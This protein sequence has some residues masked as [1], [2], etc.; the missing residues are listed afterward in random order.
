MNGKY[1]KMAFDFESKDG[2]QNGKKTIEYHDPMLGIQ[3]CNKIY[4]D[5]QEL[6]KTEFGEEARS[7]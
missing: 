7:I 4:R 6:K 3:F 5:G 2:M 1:N